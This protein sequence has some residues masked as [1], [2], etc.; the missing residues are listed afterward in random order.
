M[1]LIS[2]AASSTGLGE[3]TESDRGVLTSCKMRS[4]SSLYPSL[5]MSCIKAQWLKN[6]FLKCRDRFAWNT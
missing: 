4:P 1:S 3:E 6:S 2:L 5:W